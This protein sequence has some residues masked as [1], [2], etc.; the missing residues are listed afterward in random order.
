MYTVH[1]AYKFVLHTQMSVV[2]IVLYALS[3]NVVLIEEGMCVDVCCAVLC[4]VSLGMIDVYFSK[5]ANSGC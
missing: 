3:N 2:Y 1:I 4:C 5:M